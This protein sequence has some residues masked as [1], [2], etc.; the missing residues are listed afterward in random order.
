[1]YVRVKKTGRIT[2]QPNLLQLLW[3]SN[4]E[5]D[6]REARV[7]RGAEAVSESPP[8]TARDSSDTCLYHLVY[9]Y[10]H[11]VK[12]LRFNLVFMMGNSCSWYDHSARFMSKKNFLWEN[13][14][15]TQKT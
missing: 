3:L 4:I 14:A 12:S 1:M 9:T 6:E 7:R 5:K 13:R 15:I 11:L 2:K 10:S 8:L